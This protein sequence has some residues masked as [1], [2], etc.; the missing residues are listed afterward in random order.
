[1]K[2]AQQNKK[3]KGFTL[4]EM[5]I[6]LATFLLIAGT[7]FSL[8]IRSQQRYITDS[9]IL[10]SFQ[11]T[12]LG[13][14]QIVR[15]VDDSGYP[16]RNHFSAAATPVTFYAATPIA[17][18]PGY[19]GTTFG[20]PCTIGTTC[21]TP[22]AFD[23]IIETQFDN[24]GVNWIRYQLPAGTTTL[25]RGVTPKT[26]GGDPVAATSAAGVM[27]PYV[28]NVMN[29]ATDAQIA[30]I[31]AQ[32]PSMFP[33]GTAVPVFSYTFDPPTGTAPA[34]VA[35]AAAPCNIRDVEITLIVQAQWVDTQSGR[36][37]L[38][39]LHGKGRR[40]NPNQ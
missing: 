9:Q 5:M 30:A 23:L 32:Y 39:Q 25:L 38:V 16:P 1:M 4:L 17:W 11:E 36:L 28:Q 21:T 19:S 18:S 10:T 27:L 12:R 3:Q 26:A 37:R 8:L 14:D 34:C 6:S 22:S 31:Q 20:A 35:V 33:G 15:D 29:N 40:L 7:A 24:T 2:T 13:L